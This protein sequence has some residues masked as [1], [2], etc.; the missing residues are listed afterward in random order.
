M[1]RWSC[2]ALFCATTVITSHAPCLPTTQDLACP[3]EATRWSR[4]NKDQQSSELG[5]ITSTR[6]AFHA[7]I[8]S[9]VHSHTHTHTKGG[10]RAGGTIR[11]RS[12][13]G[14]NKSFDSP[15]SP[16]P[17]SNNRKA[18]ARLQ[19]A[20]KEAKDSGMDSSGRSVKTL[21]MGAD[22]EESNGMYVTICVE[23]FTRTQEYG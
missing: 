12:N 8:R 18:M 20:S 13:I 6:K 5:R 16:S 21:E 10:M 15:G 14:T 4:C 2:H 19:V 3:L 1:A 9:V 11:N 22:E 23:S 7:V 17:S